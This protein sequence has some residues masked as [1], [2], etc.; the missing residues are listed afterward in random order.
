MYRLSLP[1]AASLAAQFR[2]VETF[3]TSGETLTVPPNRHASLMTQA[4]GK[5]I[6]V[7][8]G[9][10]GNYEALPRQRQGHAR[11]SDTTLSAPALK[12]TGV[13]VRLRKWYY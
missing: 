12:D 7:E 1:A 8:P 10:L 11:E 13:D 9:S 6:R 4:G 5:A 2:P 3:R